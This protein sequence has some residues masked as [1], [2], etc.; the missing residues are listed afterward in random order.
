MLEEVEKAPGV[1]K[2]ELVIP[3]YL[4]NHGSYSVKLQAG[5]PGQ[6]EILESTKVLRF[7][8]EKISD[9][10]TTYNAVLKGVV[11]PKIDWKIFQE[12]DD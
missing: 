4:L 1:Y 8:V 12:K 11:A 3:P 9:S 6:R 7:D 10:G 2:Y 5:I